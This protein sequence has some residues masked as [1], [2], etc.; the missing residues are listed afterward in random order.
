MEGSLHMKEAIQARQAEIAEF[1]KR[2]GV[3]ELGHSSPGDH[4]RGRGTGVAGV[5]RR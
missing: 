4:R 2:W 1:C 3:S 5:L